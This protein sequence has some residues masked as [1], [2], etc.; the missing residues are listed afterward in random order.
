MYCRLVDGAAAVSASVPT[1]PPAL[2]CTPAASIVPPPPYSLA[3]SIGAGRVGDA[4]HPGSRCWPEPGPAGPLEA[5]ARIMLCVAISGGVLAWGSNDGLIL[6]CDA[7]T[8]AVNT[9]FVAHETGVSALA[10]DADARHI[11][12]C[13]AD[14][15]VRRWDTH[16]GALVASMSAPAATLALAASKLVPGLCCLVPL[17]HVPLI[18]DWCSHRVHPAFSNAAH[19]HAFYAALGDEDAAGATTTAARAPSVVERGLSDGGDAAANRA[20]T[21]KMMGTQQDACAQSAM[22]PS[23]RQKCEDDDAHV[24]ASTDAAV[25]A[26]P[27]AHIPDS[28]PTRGHEFRAGLSIL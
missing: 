21:H 24:E 27:A 17:G 6:C 22:H 9:L 7:D 15:F 1:G 26:A 12:S 2:S 13:G 5:A 25:A 11:M 19:E 20:N 4:V 18:I 16:T 14:G 8:G 23:K 28:A 10:W 3:L